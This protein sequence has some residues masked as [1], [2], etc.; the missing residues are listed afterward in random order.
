MAGVPWGEK[1]FIGVVC[2]WIDNNF[3]R[4]S[5][6]IGFLPE[7]EQPGSMS[8]KTSEG[9]SIILGKFLDDMLLRDK[10][11]FLLGD[12]CSTNFA[13]CEQPALRQDK[14]PVVPFKKKHSFCRCLAH[15][16]HLEAVQVIGLFQETCK[17]VSGRNNGY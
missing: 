12:N 10:L 16:V 15:V 4:N 9:L 8:S 5:A 11:S 14:G 17:K 2:H 7:V 13:M 3:E 1:S 6:L